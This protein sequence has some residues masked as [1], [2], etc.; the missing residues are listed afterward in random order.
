MEKNLDR[1]VAIV[2]GAADGI[3]FAIAQRLA[4]AGAHIAIADVN[5]LAASQ[6]AGA[7]AAEGL[8]AIPVGVDVADEHAVAAMMDSVHRELGPVEIL[9][10]NAGITGGAA[11][12]Q[13]FDI[14]AWDR[15][16]AVNLRGVF[17]CCRAALPDMLS[18]GR[19]RIVNVA[20]IAGKEG[21]PRLSAYSASKAAVIGFTKS[22]AKE[23]AQKNIIVNAISPAVI[24]TRILDQVPQETID[25]MV[26]RIPMGRTGKP[27]EVAA[28]VHWLAGDDCT[29][30]TGQCIDISGG[31][32]TY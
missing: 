11:D 13:D 10:N 18:G 25:Y 22:L 32:A 14:A 30:T 21:N 28:L 31:R 16:I 3:G 17:L 5:P 26:S 4:R 29:F 9:V 8:R 1:R 15:T 2:T 27:E 19:G 23:V 7:L 6:A 24:Q 12:V 20:S